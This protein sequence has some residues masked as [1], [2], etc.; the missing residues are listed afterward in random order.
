MAQTGKN[1]PAM[2][3]MWVRSLGWEDPLEKGMA[4]HSRILA[5]RIPMGREAWWTTVLGV[6]KSQTRL[7]N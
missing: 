7:S 2:Y 1:P 4:A 3:E 6:A 5:S